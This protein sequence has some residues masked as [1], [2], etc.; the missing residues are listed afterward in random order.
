MELGTFE[1]RIDQLVT[2]LRNFV[3]FRSLW[4]AA[5]GEIWHTEPDEDLSADGFI[6]LA[7]LME[8]SRED[9]T[10]A[11]LCVP[12]VEV[13]AHSRVARWRSPD[14]DGVGLVAASAG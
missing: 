14:L 1:T 2:S 8:P 9:L 6:Y 12:A 3:G 10:A 5:D 13:H 7:T 4:L 11:L